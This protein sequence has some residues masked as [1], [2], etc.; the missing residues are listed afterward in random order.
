MNL[1]LRIELEIISANDFIKNDNVK[2]SI[3]SK[4]FVFDSIFNR[5]VYDIEKM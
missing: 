3:F 1:F 2:S 5:E 4:K